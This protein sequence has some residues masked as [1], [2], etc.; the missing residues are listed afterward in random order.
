MMLRR[1]AG[2]RGKSIGENSGRR[3]YLAKRSFWKW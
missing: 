2:F 3:E 1:G